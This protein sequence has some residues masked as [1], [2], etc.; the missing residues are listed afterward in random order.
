MM[1]RNI[2]NSLRDLSENEQNFLAEVVGLFFEEVSSVLPRLHS[3]EVERNAKEL[4]RLASELGASSSSIGAV[5]MA[6]WCSI[7]TT[8]AQEEKFKD[9][10]SVLQKL[11]EE[12]EATKLVLDRELRSHTKARSA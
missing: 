2:L 12:Y 8:L 10:H 3:A 6:R 4:E 11:D 1:D 9:A 5:S 7:L